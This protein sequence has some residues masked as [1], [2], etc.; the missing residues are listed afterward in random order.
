MKRV[1]VRQA[2][3]ATHVEWRMRCHLPIMRA[4]VAVTLAAALIV[5]CSAPP[6]KPALPPITPIMIPPPMSAQQE[7]V[8]GVWHW[9]RGEAGGP[10][11]RDVYTLEFTAD[12]RVLVHADCNR[13]GGRYTVG[14]DASITLSAL[15]TT[16]VACPVGSQDTAFLRDLGLVERY[17]FEG[18]T[19]VLTLRGTAGTLRFSR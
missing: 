16:K 13:G 10:G 1:S 12:G 9:V 2:H 19:L 14:S 3:A 11:A 6:S 4:A 8:G 15:A 7:L 18:D 5:G 17:G